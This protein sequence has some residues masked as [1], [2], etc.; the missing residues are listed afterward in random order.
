MSYKR[1]FRCNDC[2]LLLVYIIHLS[3]VD[4]PPRL[5]T[6]YLKHALYYMKKLYLFLLHIQSVSYNLTELQI[7]N[8]YIYKCWRVCVCVCVYV[9][10]T[11]CP[12][13]S[14]E[15]EECSWATHLPA[16]TD[17]WTRPHPCVPL[18]IPPTHISTWDVSTSKKKS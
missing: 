13:G 6:I 5:G 12:D 18:Q 8:I 2:F 10:C 15:L 9:W 1:F 17:I 14:A 4:P 7:I 3:L 16:H 11:C